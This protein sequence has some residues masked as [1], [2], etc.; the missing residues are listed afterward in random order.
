MTP[1]I[2]AN[3]SFAAARLILDEAARSG[4]TD[5]MIAPGSRSTAL[6]LAFHADPR[7]HVHTHIDERSA[8]FFAAGYARITG[9][10]MPVVVTSGSAVAQLH[11]AVIEADAAGIPMLLLTAD[12]P[13][14]LRDTG[15][16]QTIRQAG[17]FGDAVRLAANIEVLEDHAA[18]DRYVRSVVQQA[19]AAAVG[20]AN[21]PG[22]V[23]LN[24]AFREPTVPVS[25]DG[26]APAA[27][28][29]EQP[30]TGRADGTPYQRVIAP[31]RQPDAAFIAA[32]A[33]K[34]QHRRGVIVA[35]VVDGQVRDEQLR[36]AVDRFA[37][38]VGWP[39]LAEAASDLARC[40]RAV[41]HVPLIVTHPLFTAAHPPEVVI[42]LGRTGVTAGLESYLKTATID[43]LVDAYGSLF[44]PD[45]HVSERVIA[46]PLA[47]I[48]ALDGAAEALE[49]TNDGV[50]A[51]A[52]ETASGTL[53]TLFDTLMLADA[54]ETLTEPATLRLLA[55]HGEA[56]DT[57]V[58]GSSM[59]IRDLDSYGLGNRQATVV[60]NRGASGIDGFV[61]TVRGVAA[62]QGGFTVG[63]CGDVTFLH[64]INGLLHNDNDTPVAVVVLDNDGGAIFS[65]LPQAAY[66][67][68]LDAV[69]AMPHGRDLIAIAAAYG[70]TTL[71]CDTVG[72]LNAALTKARTMPGVTVIRVPSD[73][74]Q[75]VAVH[76]ALRQ[77]ADEHLAEHLT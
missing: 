72:A 15:A 60:A 37:A 11:P 53:S 45:R 48:T 22:P 73:R 35:G 44:D 36:A 19:L 56:T 13:V 42:R 76:R 54:T 32:L 41:A 52:F 30:L 57:L 14:E 39:V 26:R 75:N 4:V 23:Q 2:P 47:F 71:T 28:P 74:T 3:P 6:A 21:R 9:N 7:F 62:A 65:F 49:V 24:V 12:R 55:K 16:N 64:D 1:A 27:K 59:P 25:D 5:V 40:E 38:R 43:V 77:Q 20:G 10:V 51:A 61:S 29:W 46:D 18:T 34:L 50:W 33:G 66:P 17:L 58:V 8:G 63:V 67:D 70:A 31:D 69:F 68:A